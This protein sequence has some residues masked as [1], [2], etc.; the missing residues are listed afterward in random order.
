M[1]PK[2]N[3]TIQFLKSYKQAKYLQN[4]W[5]SWYF[6]TIGCS[7][8]ICVRF[9]WKKVQDILDKSGFGVWNGGVWDNYSASLVGLVSFWIHFGKIRK[10]LA[11]VTLTPQ[12][13]YIWFGDTK[14]LQ[15]IQ[16]NSDAFIIILF[17]SISKSWKSSFS[18]VWTYSNIIQPKSS[19]TRQC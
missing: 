3:R 5:E 4:I 18:K 9:L 19:R 17:S 12:N 13:N 1:Q 11:G 16:E 8:L 14:I 6:P 10:P 15:M 2:S 7:I